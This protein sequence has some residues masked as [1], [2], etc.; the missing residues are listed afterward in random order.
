M[1]KCTINELEKIEKKISYLKNI[2]P[3]VRVNNIVILS[4]YQL[5]CLGALLKKPIVPGITPI[6]NID[7]VSVK[8]ALKSLQKKQMYFPRF[9]GVGE[10]D[11][12]VSA[13]MEQLC[14]PGEKY[15]IILNYRAGKVIKFFASFTKGA[16]VLLFKLN[17]GNYVL[18]NCEGVFKSESIY[19]VGEI[20]AD[21]V[22]RLRDE[23]T[24]SLGFCEVK[25]KLAAL[26]NDSLFVNGMYDCLCGKTNNGMFCKYFFDGMKFRKFESGFV[27]CG[28]GSGGIIKLRR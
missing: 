3:D 10:V 21:V 8:T 1:N 14:A 22:K 13:L 23:I 18:C 7:D 27:V 4:Q 15:E 20:S 16:S 11:E 2:W 19:S 12:T 9:S 5:L 24:Q 26:N 17:E 28:N 25:E 6:I